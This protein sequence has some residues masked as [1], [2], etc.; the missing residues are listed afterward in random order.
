MFSSKLAKRGFC[1]LAIGGIKIFE[2]YF[3]TD[4]PV[5]NKVNKLPIAIVE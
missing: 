5:G 2:N 3:L 4:R 1:G